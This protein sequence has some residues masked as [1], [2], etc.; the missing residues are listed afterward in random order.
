MAQ[1]TE[2]HDARDVN[3][4]AFEMGVRLSWQRSNGPDLI[5]AN[6][7]GAKQRQKRFGGRKNYQ[8]CLRRVVKGKVGHW[9]CSSRGGVGCCCCASKF[10]VSLDFPF[11]NNSDFFEGRKNWEVMKLLWNIQDLKCTAAKSNK[12]KT[13]W[14]LYDDVAMNVTCRVSSEK[15][16]SVFL[17][18]NNLEIVASH[19]FQRN[20]W[21]FFQ[22]C[23]V[24]IFCF[25]ENPELY[26]T[27]KLLHFYSLPI[28]WISI[29]TTITEQHC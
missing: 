6:R 10:A 8:H 11:P 9:C 5:V 7:N 22:L 3:T 4:H 25:R 1:L 15:V 28:Q 18:N 23:L 14:V 2:I 13:L 17:A 16:A 12:A 19:S 21:P 27:K 20:L 29:Y 24:A 26:H